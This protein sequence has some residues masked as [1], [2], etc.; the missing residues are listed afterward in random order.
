MHSF[1]FPLY[2]ISCGI[3][4]DQNHVLQI[5]MA[6]CHG[7]L[8]PVYEPYPHRC[9]VAMSVSLKPSEKKQCFCVLLS[10][11]IKGM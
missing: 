8:I 3:L 9:M 4:T 10:K 11:C 7:F 5:G 1:Q 2:K 6:I